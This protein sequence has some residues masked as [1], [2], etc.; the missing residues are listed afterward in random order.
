M[1]IPITHDVFDIVNRIKN[2]DKEVDALVL[3]STHNIF[4][5]KDKERREHINELHRRRCLCR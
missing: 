4:D 3:S 5:T 1:R 2:I